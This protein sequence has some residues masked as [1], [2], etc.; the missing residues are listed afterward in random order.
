MKTFL[1]LLIST[2][3]ACNTPQPVK[4]VAQP[5]Q[6]TQSPTLEDQSQPRV[7]T[8]EQ[9]KMCSE[10]AEKQF[11]ASEQSAK[12]FGAS[13]VSD[14]TSHYDARANVCYM[15]I[16][17]NSA[18]K[19]VVSFVETVFDAFEGRGYASYIWVNAGKK[20]YW[21]VAPKTCLVHPRGQP[22]IKCKSSDEFDALVE[23]YFGIGK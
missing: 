10:Q 8:L 3:V 1:A 20:Q 17:A 21:E 15:R 23:K 7:A 19:N 6:P 2:L 22:E 12:K 14:Y 16:Y 13:G 5:V 18:S 4:Q 11:N 9:Q